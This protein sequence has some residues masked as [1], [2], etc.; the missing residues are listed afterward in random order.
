MSNKPTLTLLE[1]VVDVQQGEVISIYVRKSHLGLVSSFL[2]LIRAHKALRYCS[3]NGETD[4]APPQPRM[5][6]GEGGYGP[7]IKPHPPHR[8]KGT[9]PPGLLNTLLQPPKGSYTRL[10]PQP[11]TLPPQSCL[12]GHQSPRRA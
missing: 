6:A 7:N 1:G 11:P 8:A 9:G 12:L 10:E 2:G 3:K 4:P 5:T